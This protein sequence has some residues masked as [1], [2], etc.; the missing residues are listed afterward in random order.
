[1]DKSIDFLLENAGPVIR[2]R[3]RKEI[4]CDLS[5]TEEEN[6][7]ERIYQMPLFKKLLE[8][9]KPSGFIG[10]A[11]HNNND[12]QVNE[13]DDG[14]AAARLLSNY[15]IPKDHPLI[16]NYIAAMRNEG[17]LQEAF[18]YPGYMKKFF[19]HRFEAL[20]N[21]NSMLADIYAM[22]AML[23]YGDDEEV[24]YFQEIC[25]TGFKRVIEAGSLEEI[26]HFDPKIKTNLKYRCHI[27]PDDYFP[28]S[29]T[30]ANLAY[31]SAWRTPENIRMM[32]DAINHINA[33]MPEAGEAGLY[34]MM[35]KQLKGPC[36]AF[37][38]P[39]Q[40]FTADRQD[41]VYYRRPLTE[42][43]M[44]GVGER[45]GVLRESAANVEEALAADGILRIP[46]E[47]S[48]FKRRYIDQIKL[49]TPYGDIGLEE[50][51]RSETAIWCNLTFWAVQ[52]LTLV[53]NQ[54]TK[55]NT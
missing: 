42:I 54:T 27:D 12:R 43:A 46:F 2:Y 35:F 49:P 30:L 5:K 33:I 19:D 39:F 1:M 14:E 44:L 50:S 8:C 9:V 26:T 47:S 15:A 52:F 18:S 11:M 4:L 13:M 3:L 20:N 31:T 36:F 10:V 51:Y 53:K 16:R 38:R 25:L 40:A 34:V 41:V 45:C 28:C 24:R 48:Y 32:A 7:L 37:C 6:L 21:G 22:Q 17:A 29:Y 55:K 23:G